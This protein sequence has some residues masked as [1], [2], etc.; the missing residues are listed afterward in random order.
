M[1]NL[2]LTKGLCNGTRLMIINIKKYVI[3]TNVFSGPQ[4]GS[5][6]FIPRKVCI[7]TKMNN[8]KYSKEDNILLN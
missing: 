3:E 2:N 7:P 4:K 5:T 8:H 1:R 6:I